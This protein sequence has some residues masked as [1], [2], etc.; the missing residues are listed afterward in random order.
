MLLLVLNSRIGIPWIITLYQGILILAVLCSIMC[1]QIAFF[2][3]RK[4]A[5]KLGVV[6]TTIFLYRDLNIVAITGPFIPLSSKALLKAL[7]S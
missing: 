3:K 6:V 5:E 2:S 7:R 1:S 4:L